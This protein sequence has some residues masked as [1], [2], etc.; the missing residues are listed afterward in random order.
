VRGI[1]AA[2]C[3][4]LLAGCDESMDRQNRMKT[5]GSASGMPAWPAHGEALPLVVG[6]VPQGQAA[7][8]QELAEPPS[9]SPV[10]LQRGRARYDIYCAACH[11]LTGAGDGIVVARGFP[12]P[13]PFDDPRLM[14]A[15][16][17]HLVDVIGQGS[18]VMFSLAD[19]VEPRDRW[20][21]AA[22]IR[23]LQLADHSR[24]APP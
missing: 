19:R 11:G 16:A 14:Q 13:A 22:Y 23:A 18:G 20:A 12:K 8:A 24:K 5:Y 15:S 17:R 3:L 4:L 9:V 10:L 21:I 7:R 6:T 2:L 1:A